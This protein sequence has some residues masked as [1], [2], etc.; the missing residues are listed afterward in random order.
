[1]TDQ[2]KNTLRD[3]WEPIGQAPEPHFAWCPILE[4]WIDP[5]PM[6]AL[7]AAFANFHENEKRVNAKW[8]R[9][10][11]NLPPDLKR[12]LSLHDFK[13]LGDLFKEAFNVS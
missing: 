11:N 7:R 2:I 6:T 5:T 12:K 3:P 4:K 10:Y 13:R 1:M 8:G 9:W